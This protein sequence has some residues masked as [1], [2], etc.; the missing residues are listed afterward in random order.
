M[1]KKTS[2]KMNYGEAMAEIEKILASLQEENADVD[3]LAERV[4][5]ASELIAACRAKLRK[6]ESDV[7]AI[8]EKENE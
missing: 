2:D 8:F 6:A 5:R 1:A 4:K 7:N 3:T